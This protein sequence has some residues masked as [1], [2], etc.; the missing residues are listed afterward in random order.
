MGELLSHTLNLRIEHV[1]SCLN[2]MQNPPVLFLYRL[3]H[4]ILL[5]ILKGEQGPGKSISAD[6]KVF[7]LCWQALSEAV[8]QKY[9]PFYS[10]SEPPYCRGTKS[11]PPSEKHNY[12]GYNESHYTVSCCNSLT[13]G[14]HS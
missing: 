9:K 1:Y 12:I 2:K 14:A 6:I 4:E 3:R 5:F 7:A 11:A 8:H 13:A 10:I